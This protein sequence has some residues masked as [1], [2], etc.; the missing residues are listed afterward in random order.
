MRRLLAALALSVTV[1]SCGGDDPDRV[2][3]VTRKCEI[4]TSASSTGVVTLVGAACDSE[5]VLSRR[6]EVSVRTARGTTYT[7]DMEP[8]TAVT[9]GAEWPPND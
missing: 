9:V 8:G 6:L 5:G 3:A 7:V 4:R 2:V 1:A